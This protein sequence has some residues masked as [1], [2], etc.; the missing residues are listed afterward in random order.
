MTSLFLPPGP[1]KRIAASQSAFHPLSHR[2][3]ARRKPF[4]A[5]EI[6]ARALAVIAEDGGCRMYLINGKPSIGRLTSSGRRHLVA[7]YDRKATAEM[8][9]EDARDAFGW[10]A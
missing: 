6:A 5:A 4:D 9:A 3:G 7:T 1:G 10:L 8:I 2:R